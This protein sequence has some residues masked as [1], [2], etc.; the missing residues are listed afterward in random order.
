MLVD[1]GIDDTLIL[2]YKATSKALNVK[3]SV[4]FVIFKRMWRLTPF[5]I[6]LEESKVNCMTVG[7]VSVI[8][9]KIH[10]GHSD[11]ISVSVNN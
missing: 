6:E 5:Q 4:L 10:Q 9:Q 7:P 8:K 3:L 11:S 1:L 2:T